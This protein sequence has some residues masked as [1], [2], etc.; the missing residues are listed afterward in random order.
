MLSFYSQVLS[1]I[2]DLRKS[3]SERSICYTETG[4]EIHFQLDL[5]CTMG[6]TCFPLVYDLSPRIPA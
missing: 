2:F 6:I 5:T 4:N 1:Q 3:P